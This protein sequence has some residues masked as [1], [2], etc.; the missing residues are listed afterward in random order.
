MIGWYYIPPG[1]TLAAKSSLTGK[2]S[3]T[4]KSAGGRPAT[5]KRTPRPVLV[6]SGRRTFYAAAP[7]V[8]KIH[9]TTAG[10][11]L[12]EHSKEIRLTA[13]AVFTPVGKAAI[14]VSKKFELR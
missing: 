11:R 8:I 13:R 6:A 2:S 12:L 9:L 5:K 1:A 10:R 7:G 4:G 14:T 3:V